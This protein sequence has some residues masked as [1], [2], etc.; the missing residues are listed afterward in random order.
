MVESIKELR[1]ICKKS[2]EEEDALPTK[3]D[4][5]VWTNIDRGAS[6]YFTKIFLIMG[7]SANKVT[8]IG[9]LFGVCAGV[10]FIL[11]DVRYWLLGTLFSG[12]SGVIDCADGEVAR[13]NKSVSEL[14]GY[15]SSVAMAFLSAYRLLCM[16]IGIY[17]LLQSPTVLLVGLLI[18]TSLFLQRHLVVSEYTFFRQV[19]TN[20]VYS[21]PFVLGKD[22]DS[23][24]ILSHIMRYGTSFYYNCTSW[25]TLLVIVLIDCFIPP[26]VIGSIILNAR[27][28]YLIL[29]ALTM[30]VGTILLIVS[31][32]RLVSAKSTKS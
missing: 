22:E 8:L 29:C 4:E 24:P 17:L 10:F 16:S 1:K 25:Y 7:L 28:L 19:K 15:L 30:C 31:G 5:F 21:M 9:F 13:Y 20:E 14:G 23:I 12:L 18:V 32:S 2:D 27:Y 3:W 6:I 26:F 11:G